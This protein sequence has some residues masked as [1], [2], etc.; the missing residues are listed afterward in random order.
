MKTIFSGI[1]SETTGTALSTA[2]GGR[3]YLDYAPD[4]A[5]LPNIVYSIVTD[6]QEDTFT[7]SIDDMIIQF[8]IFHNSLSGS[9]V[10]DI[11]DALRAVFDDAVITAAGYTPI[12]MVHE[13]LETMVD[14]FTTASGSEIIRHWAVDYRLVVQS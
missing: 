10:A 1:M 14:E 7:D 11:Y 9:A 5:S 13:N 6:S 2:V 12:M 8:S 3:I 4:G